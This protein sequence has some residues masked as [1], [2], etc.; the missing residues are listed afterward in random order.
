MKSAAQVTF[1]FERPG[2]EVPRFT[3]SV[4]EGGTARYEAEQVLANTR[5]SDADASPATQHIDRQIVLSQATTKRI[6][7]AALELNRFNEPCA[8]AAKNIADTGKKT[9]KYTGEGG[10]GTCVYHYS[11]DKRVVMLTETFEAIATTL[12][13]GRKLDFDHRFDRLGLDALTVHLVQ[14]VEAG[15]AIEVGAIAPTL[16]SLAG[17]S[18]VMERVRSRAA[19]LLQQAKPAS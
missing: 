16:R 19:K 18:E 5:T 17:D 10:E 2:L 15:R 1:Q 6:F 9:L 14:E 13:I 8:S 3:L 4:N 7:A 12:D 11:Q